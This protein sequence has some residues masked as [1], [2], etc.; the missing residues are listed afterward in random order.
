MELPFTV[1]KHQH[2]IIKEKGYWLLYWGKY[3]TEIIT[4]NKVNEKFIKIEV[5]YKNKSL[6][7]CY[8]FYKCSEESL[9]SKKL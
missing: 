7:E 9:F 2:K 5:I 1:T 3:E 4:P 8:A 6:A